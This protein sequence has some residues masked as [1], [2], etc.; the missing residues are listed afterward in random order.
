MLGKLL[1]FGLAIVAV[2]IAS[3]SAVAQDSWAQKLVEPQK[4]DFGVIAAGSESVRVLTIENTTKAVVHIVGATPGCQCVMPGEPSQRVLQPGEKATLEVRMNTRSYK[5]ERHTFLTIT[6]DAPQ[7]D[8]VRIP[9]YA[10]IRT[11]VVFTPGKIDFGSVEI[12]TGGEVTCKIAYAGR[13][14]WKILNVKYTN[15][16]LNATLDEIGR[17]PGLGTVDYELKMTLAPDARPGR[18]REMITIV[19][20]DAASPNVP[21]MVEGVVTSDIRLANE[22]VSVGTLKSG[23]VAKNQFVILGSKPF[24]VEGV[25][26]RK[27]PDSL[28]ATLNEVE[29]KQQVVKFEFTAPDSPGKFAE[30][31]RVRIKGREETYKFT[32]SGQIR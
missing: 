10:Y 8:I 26:C 22:S 23:E 11:D 28:K 5:H 7:P 2:F 18:I 19:T 3:T 32:V 16:D 9:V 24:V 13:P 14:D 29:S 17:N 25:E 21:L 12:G 6:F 4:L 30:E 27:F 31:V 20:D 1:I 15:K